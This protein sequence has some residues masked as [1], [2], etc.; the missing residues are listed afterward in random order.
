M[1]LPE[2]VRSRVAESV[3]GTDADEIEHFGGVWVNASIEVIDGEKL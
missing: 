1:E 2:L 3:E